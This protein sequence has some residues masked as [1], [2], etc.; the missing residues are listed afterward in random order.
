MK[1]VLSDLSQFF[2]G[3]GERKL[4]LYAASGAYYIFIAIVPVIMLIVSLVQ[5]LPITA[6]YI[7][8]EISSLLPAQVTDVLE[9]IVRG[10]YDNGRTALTISIV[11]TVFSASAAMRAIMRGLDAAYSGDKQNILL[12]YIR[13]M[14]YMLIFVAVLLISFVIMAYGGAI[15]KFILNLFPETTWLQPLFSVLRY[16][17]YIAV[18]LLLFLVFIFMY[19]FIPVHHI[20]K[21]AQWPGALLVSVGWVLFSM[22]FSAYLAYSNRFGAYGIIGTV[23]AAMMWLYYSIFFVLIGGWLNSFIAIKKAEQRPV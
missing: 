21:I 1:R 13:S 5:F 23:M 17:R 22:A 11:L 15:M 12:Y 9:R 4:P 8:S 14:F 6:D 7:M 10:I 19:R 16:A 3:I 2:V 18:M 20:R